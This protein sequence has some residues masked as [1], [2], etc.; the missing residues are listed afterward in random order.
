VKPW[1]FHDLRRSTATQLG[2]LGVQPH[3]IECV[4]GHVSGFRAGVA[5]IYNKS[6][7][8]NEM[9]NALAIWGDHVR[10]IVEGGEHKVVNF[11]QAGS[12]TA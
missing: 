12:D 9:R 8:F 11:P 7:Y 2:N 5:S 4:L 10:T 1:R 6:P 3:V